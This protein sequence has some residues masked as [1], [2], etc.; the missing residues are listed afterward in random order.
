MSNPEPILQQVVIQR[1]LTNDTVAQKYESSG[2]HKKT[3][4][5]IEIKDELNIERTTETFKSNRKKTASV[6]PP[7]IK[8]PSLEI[9]S[10]KNDYT[11][12]NLIEKLRQ[13]DT[14]QGTQ[15]YK[16]PQHINFD[17]KV[18]FEKELEMVSKELQKKNT[19]NN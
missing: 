17:A 14:S 15:Q 13:S 6:E 16:K 19:S 5:K 11:N 2:T 3:L 10:K 4:S 12:E 8:T 9:F 18:P 7:K 1:K